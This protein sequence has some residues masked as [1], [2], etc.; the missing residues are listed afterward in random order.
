MKRE[1][2]KTWYLPEFDRMRLLP[3]D[4]STPGTCQ[5]DAL[6]VLSMRQTNNKQQSSQLE[7]RRGRCEQEKSMGSRISP[8]ARVPF[9]A[10]SASPYLAL[11]RRPL[12]GNLH[13][14]TNRH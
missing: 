12:L 3:A 5:Q 7:G 10:V 8:E 6:C 14:G 1:A 2:G 9:A 4:E 13:Y 11:R